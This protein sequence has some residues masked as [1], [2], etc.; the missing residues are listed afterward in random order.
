VTACS[1]RACVR[2]G[3]VKPLSLFPPC[4][5][6]LLGRKRRCRACIS[7][8]SRDRQMQR[9]Y[10]ISEAKRDELVKMQ[11]GNCAI[12]GKPE[13]EAPRQRL[14]VDHCHTTG[15]V[16]GMLCDH[17]NKGIGCLQDDISNLTAAIEYLSQN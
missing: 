9:D 6:S 1:D 12:C 2:C 14:A 10:G 11:G 13:S 16:R 7:E 5:K 8:Q 4:K 3:E 17:C 15:K